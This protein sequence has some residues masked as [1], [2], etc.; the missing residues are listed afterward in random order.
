MRDPKNIRQAEEA[1][2]D[3]MGFIF[4]NGFSRFVGDMEPVMTGLV[5]RV[6]VFVNED[7]D[8]ILDVADEWELD[9]VQLHGNETPEDCAYIANHGIEVIKTFSVGKAF[10]FN[11]LDPYSL[12]VDYFLF[13]TKGRHY[14]GNGQVFDWSILEEYDYDVPFFLSGGIHPGLAYEI[15]KLNF[16]MLYAVDVNSGFEEKPGLKNINQLKQFIDELQGR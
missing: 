13:D 14:G 10:D 2:V 11:R 9:T 7:P 6:G 3:I 5:E 4:Y 8:E 15:S 16:P 1:G 12:A